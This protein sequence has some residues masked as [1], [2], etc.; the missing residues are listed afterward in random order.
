MHVTISGV[1]RGNSRTTGEKI[2][3]LVVPFVQALRGAYI[4][5]GISDDESATVDMLADILVYAAKVESIE[6]YT[7]ADQAARS[8]EGELH[9]AEAGA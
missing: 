2:D 9:D 3:R 8:A 5:A 6:V 4:A 1:P 7:L